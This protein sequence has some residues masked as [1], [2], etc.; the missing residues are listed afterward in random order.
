MIRT[1]CVSPL[2]FSLLLGLA[3]SACGGKSLERPESLPLRTY[4]ADRDFRMSFVMTSCSDPCA[5]Y[6]E[7]ECSVDVD[8][9][10]RVIEV[11]V[12]VGY[13]DRDGV[14]RATCALACGKPVLGHCDVP[15]VPAG[16][17]T[18]VSGVFSADIDVR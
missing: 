2:I 11:S 3:F 13:S 7:S 10:D 16:R 6:E 17:Y 1:R 18:V 8:T 14:D 5:E 15:A 9:E 12:S 4:P